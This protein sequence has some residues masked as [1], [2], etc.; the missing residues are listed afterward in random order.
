MGTTGGFRTKDRGNSM[1]QLTL[2]ALMALSFSAQ[3]ADVDVATYTK[4][5]QFTDLKISPGGDYYAATVPLED[6]TVLV[7]LDRAT[8]KISGSLTMSAISAG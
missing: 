4:R 6:R 5:D 1:K 8:N 3:A 7:V 2:A